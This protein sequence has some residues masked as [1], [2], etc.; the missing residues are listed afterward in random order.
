MTGAFVGRSVDDPLLRV[1][2][3]LVLTSSVVLLGLYV[4]AIFRPAD[5]FIER[6]ITEDAYYA[7]S[8]SRSIAAGTGFSVDGVHPTN[9]VQPL[10]C[11]LYA[12]IYLSTPEDDPISPLRLVLAL[13]VLI[14]IAGAVLAARLARLTWPDEADRAAWLVFGLYFVNYSLGVHL[15]NGLE[16]GLT[17]ALL[18]GATLFSWRMIEEGDDRIRSAVLL[19]SILGLS[20]LSRI[21]AGIFCAVLGLFLLAG[22][23]EFEGVRFVRR[24]RT[25]AVSAVTALVVSAPW[26]VYGLTTF[27]HPMPVSGQSQYDLGG[28]L[29][30]VVAATLTSLSDAL[31]PGIHAPEGSG[32]AGL[33]PHGLAVAI[34]AILVVLVLRRRVPVDL[35]PEGRFVLEPS[36]PLLVTSGLLSV[37]YTLAFRA[38]HF[39]DRYLV[40][41]QLI[42]IFL[43]TGVVLFLWRRQQRS[44]M[45][46]IATV[47]LPGL[48]FVAS[49]GLT[50]R[51]FSNVYP[52]PLIPTLEWIESE[53]TSD[54]RIGI[55][56]SGTS[57]YFF[58]D[59]VVNL[60]GKVNVAAHEAYRGGRLGEYVIDQSFD[61]VADW[62]EY[63]DR[64]D[65][66]SSFRNNYRPID[67]LRNFFVV[68]QKKGE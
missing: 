24:F 62:P 29:G 60:D 2:R 23:R 15:L 59:R 45:I 5:R 13:Q 38:P 11:L 50:S 32:I 37:V 51:L 14:G 35:R 7:L 30:S 36:M 40:L 55:F 48:L 12:P 34:L 44:T 54:D 61:Y 6:P 47:V 31:V 3:A 49:I 64:L 65:A 9:G 67:T 53:T 22:Y 39:Q 18:I 25:V 46:R 57:G 58:P 41:A 68:M 21:D 4:V 63:L 16:T 26:W 8:V 27:G 66:S 28:S 20:V 56:Q 19:G 17:T 42:G 33:A 10:I 52:N 1:I 43:T